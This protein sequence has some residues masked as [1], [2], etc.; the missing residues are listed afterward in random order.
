MQERSKNLQNR[1]KTLDSIISKT[2]KIAIKKEIIETIHSKVNRLHH[3]IVK[4]RMERV[5]VKDDVSHIKKIK[6]EIEIMMVCTKYLGDALVE[7]GDEIKSVEKISA[8]LSSQVTKKDNIITE[9]KDNVDKISH[10]N[11]VQCKRT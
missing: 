4:E 11:D 7:M 1:S 6:K 8:L 9:Q 3:R 2:T 10:S 5:D